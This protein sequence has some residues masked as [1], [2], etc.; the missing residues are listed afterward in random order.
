[1]TIRRCNNSRTFLTCSPVCWIYFYRK[2]VLKL[3]KRRLAKHPS[4][5]YYLHSLWCTLVLLLQMVW[6][7]CRSV[8]LAVLPTDQADD[9]AGWCKETV[10]YNSLQ[11]KKHLLLTFSFWLAVFA[12][13]TAEAFTL[14][15]I[16]GL[17]IFDF[18]AFYKQKS[19]LYK[20]ISII[21][22][23][24]SPLSFHHEYQ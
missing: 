13:L 3:V 20:P 16:G 4:P 10:K 5:V 21:V 18:M 17:T 6:A 22:C 19:L 1:M 15:A 14:L 12:L 2:M 11:D 23:S 8:S 9:E 24:N 7:V